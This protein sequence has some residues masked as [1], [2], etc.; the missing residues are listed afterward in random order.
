VYTPVL[1]GSARVSFADSKLGIAATRDVLLAAP[2]GEGAV[3]VDW[4]Q[5]ASLDVAHDALR[6]EPE[7]DASYLPLPAAA[8]QP[9]NYA[10]WKKSLAARLAETERI[11]LLRHAASKLT[12]RPDESERDFRIRAQEALRSARDEAVDAMRRKYASRQATLAERLRRAQAAVGRESEQASH[13]KLQTA[14]SF[15]ATVLGAIFG[16]KAASAANVGRATTTARGV[17]RSM[18]EASDVKRA[19]ETVQAIEEQIAALETEVAEQAAAVASEF[20]TH[21]TFERVS[22]APKRGQ[23]SVNFVALGWDPQ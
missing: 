23:V 21:L 5:A 13:Q 9:K 22:V 3:P 11:E 4:E 7:E 12:S 16:R 15:G 1:L 19:S 18:K 14:V 17:G 10:I 20:E 2:I 6:Q 8:A